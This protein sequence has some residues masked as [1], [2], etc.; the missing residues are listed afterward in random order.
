M[1]VQQRHESPELGDAIV[2]MMRALVTRA[3]EGDT[4]A[5][6]QLRRIEQLAPSA[7]SLGYGWA[8][9]DAGYSWGEL[10]QVTGTSRQAVLKRAVTA[11]PGPA[12]QLVPGHRKRGCAACAY[13]AAAAS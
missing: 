4:E 2:R 9:R 5:V 7:T 12:H 11:E 8:H 13:D 3:G 1:S 6:E 10:A